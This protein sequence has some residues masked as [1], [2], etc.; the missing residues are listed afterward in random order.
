MEQRTLLALLFSLPLLMG[1][2]ESQRKALTGDAC[3]K[4]VVRFEDAYQQ[5]SKI[6]QTDMDCTCFSSISNELPF[7]GGVADH[8][9]I[10]RLQSISQEFYAAGCRTT[11]EC[12]KHEC[13]AHCVR[14]HCE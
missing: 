12:A 1:C 10:E 11:T 4:I 14:G 8:R 2:R 13:A 9:T 5:S 6:C 7:C 3:A